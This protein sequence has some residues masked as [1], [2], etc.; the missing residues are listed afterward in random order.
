MEIS[1]IKTIY[2]KKDKMHNWSHIL[3]IKRNIKILRRPYKNIDGDLLTFLINFHGLKEYIIKHKTKFNKSHI[4]SLLR[5]H[6]K[7]ILIEEK[8]VYDANLLDNIGR[9]GI[10]KALYVGSKI[11]RKES[12]TYKYLKNNLKPEELGTNFSKVS[13]SF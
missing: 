13:F 5:S 4:K 6:K 10:K 8:L 3:C 2:K 12:E 1:K 11:G 9:H 7:P